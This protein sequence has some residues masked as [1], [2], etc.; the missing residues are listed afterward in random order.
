VGSRK[1]EAIAS[2]QALLLL[3]FG[4]PPLIKK[5]PS[6]TLF[7]AILVVGLLLVDRSKKA[8]NEYLR[9]LIKQE[10]KT[11]VATLYNAATFSLVMLGLLSLSLASI[12]SKEGYSRTT[13]S[14]MILLML[15]TFQVFYS[16][17]TFSRIVNIA[18]SLYAPHVLALELAGFYEMPIIL[19]ISAI[20]RVFLWV[21]AITLALRIF[22]LNEQGTDLLPS[23][24]PLIY[25]GWIITM[26]RLVD[27]FYLSLYFRNVIES[28]ILI[29]AWMISFYL[30]GKR[31]KPYTGSRA[32][33]ISFSV[34]GVLFV[35]VPPP[36]TM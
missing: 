30:L 22:K 3:I 23:L 34:G 7:P 16:P 19:I 21:L 32:Y 36:M 35:L 27:Y 8:F 25:A 11:N 26:I 10:R 6:S 5:L 13:I 31:L 24:F 2:F 1:L 15:Y 12:A 28:L 4:T 18:V 9:D 17:L 14:F 20:F 33:L 29:S